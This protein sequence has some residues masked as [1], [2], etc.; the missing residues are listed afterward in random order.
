[1]SF[2]GRPLDWIELV[3]VEEDDPSK[4]VPFALY[5]LETPDGRMMHGRLDENGK[6]LVSGI[7]HGECKVTW[8]QHVTKQVS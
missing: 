1:M 6:S 3:L 2:C 4:P 8:L 7:K 5:R